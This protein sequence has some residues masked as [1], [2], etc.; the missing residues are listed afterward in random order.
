M[1]QTSTINHTKTTITLLLTASITGLIIGLALGIQLYQIA[2]TKLGFWQNNV[3]STT[4]TVL[5]IR[6]Q[7]QSSTRIRTTLQLGNTGATAI[8]CN[9]TLY[10]KSSA[11]VSLATYSFNTTLAAGQIKTE[12]MIIT[13]IDVAEFMGTDLSVYEY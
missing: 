1:N 13:P 12:S 10:Y 8:N 2:T 5:Q 9:C 11:G 7:I 3:E 4:L 6:H